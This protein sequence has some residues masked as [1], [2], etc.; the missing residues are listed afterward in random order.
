MADTYP[1]IK[2]FNVAVDDTHGSVTFLHKV[3]LGKASG[4][5]GIHVAKLA[6]LPEELTN[7]AEALLKTF[8]S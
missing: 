4:S 1:A 7:R 6:G 3:I 2:N 5:Y 8:E